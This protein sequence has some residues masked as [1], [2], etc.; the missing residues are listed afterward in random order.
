MNMLIH[1]RGEQLYHFDVIFNEKTVM[2]CNHCNYFANINIDTDTVVSIH[3]LLSVL[4]DL[5]SL[6]RRNDFPSIAHLNQMLLG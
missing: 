6:V 3:Y 1:T 4:F 2:C 5:H